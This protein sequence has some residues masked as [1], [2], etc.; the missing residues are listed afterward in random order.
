LWSQDWSP[1][2]SLSYGNR[3]SQTQELSINR[4]CNNQ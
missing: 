3:L 2:R 4:A 1:L